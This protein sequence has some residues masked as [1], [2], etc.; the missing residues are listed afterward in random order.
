[1]KES[2]D[3][4]IRFH[5]CRQCMQFKSG[6]WGW[7]IFD[8]L[9]CTRNNSTFSSADSVKKNQNKFHSDVIKRTVN[10]HI[11]SFCKALGY[12]WLVKLPRY[13]YILIQQSNKHVIQ[14]DKWKIQHV[15]QFP[16]SSF[17]KHHISKFKYIKP[18]WVRKPLVF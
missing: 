14:N 17:H 4:D 6:C 12:D 7:R 2:Q 10:F 8:V 18:S 3:E 16:G 15:H 13:N 9:W 11:I 5:D 1:L